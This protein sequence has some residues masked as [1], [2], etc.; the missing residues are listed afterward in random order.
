MQFCRIVDLGA[1]FANEILSTQE[2]LRTFDAGVRRCSAGRILEGLASYEAELQLL[3]VV[4][5]QRRLRHP[6]GRAKKRHNSGLLC[7]TTA[8][9]LAVEP[10][11]WLSFNIFTVRRS[12]EMSCGKAKKA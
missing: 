6:C 4:H 5:G 11:A 10:T 7:T 3:A 2:G 9:E 12:H 1:V 8:S